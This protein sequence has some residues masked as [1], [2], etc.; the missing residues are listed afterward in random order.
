MAKRQKP[1]G[2]G[3]DERCAQIAATLPD[4]PAELLRAAFSAVE[5]IDRSVLAGEL[6]AADAARN[7]YEAIV[8]KLNG[9]TMFASLDG[10]EAPGNVVAAHCAAAP[11]IAPGWAQ[12]GEF[13][14]TAAG[15]RARVVVSHGFKSFG[16]HF[17][18]HAVD[19]DRPFISQT[20]F[21]SHFQSPVVGRTVEQMAAAVLESLVAEQGGRVA[22]DRASRD[23]IEVPAWVQTIAPDD[24]P[25]VYADKKGQLCFGF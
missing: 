17:A 5:S 13:L 2:M 3:R 1:E 6:D 8:W 12:D 7:T 23:R 16:R 11:G 4:D 22:I 20:G 25:A 9:G 24:G 21:R 10:P 19:R 18:F 14:V 15:V